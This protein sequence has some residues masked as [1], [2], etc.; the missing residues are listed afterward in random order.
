MSSNLNVERICQYCGKRFT[1]HT[2]VTKYCSRVC[3]GKSNKELRRK[4]KLEKVAEEITAY[5][6]EQAILNQKDYMSCQEVADMMGIS[7]TTVYRYCI[8][9]RMNCIK[10]NR[11]IFIRRS[12]IEL[13]FDNSQPY[14]VTPIER[15]P[16]TEFYSMDE[17]TEKYN[18]SQS[19]V[20]NLVKAKN[21][22]K[23]LH[24][25]KAA[26]SKKHIDK[27]FA[28]KAPDPNITE[29]YTLEEIKE[30]YGM[31][32]NSVYTFVSENAIPRKKVKSKAFYS[33]THLDSLLHKRLSNNTIT[34]WYTMKDIVERYHLEPMYVSNL[35]YKN[36]IPKIRRGGKGHY[37]KE[38]F[39]R[40]MKEKFPVP[41][42]YTVKEAMA[43]FKITRDALYHYLTY[44]KIPKIKEGRIIK[45]EKEP[46][47]KILKEPIIL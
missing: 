40:L 14:E 3:A 32:D 29:W 28:L 17:I 7:R 44:H 13:L 4:Q 8:T 30:K 34:E 19:M 24:R 18:V 33:K 15:E 9:D 42:Y 12:D 25:N 45:I 1:A 26:Y 23:V 43:K 22:P 10:M 16:I 38:H 5:E 2:T 31:S 27:Q 47:D 21:I 6:N 37:S 39:D 11:K 46:I 20:F 41:E 36:P 35:I